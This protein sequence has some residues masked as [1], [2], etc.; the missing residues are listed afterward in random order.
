MKTTEKKSIEKVS[1]PLFLNFMTLKKLTKTSNLAIKCK[2]WQNQY[3]CENYCMKLSLKHW[4]LLIRPVSGMAQGPVLL[5]LIYGN[6]LYRPRSRIVLACSI[7]LK[8]DNFRIFY[9]IK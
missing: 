4:C 6:P 3:K 5:F 2:I 9:K 8:M 7:Q 1:M